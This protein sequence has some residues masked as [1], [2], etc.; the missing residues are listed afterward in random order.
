MM[1]D[2]RTTY[3]LLDNAISQ[4][5]F[6]PLLDYDIATESIK[7]AFVRSYTVSGDGL[8]YTFTVR[9]DVSW[10]H[11]RNGEVSAVR[12]VTAQDA[13][14]SSRATLRGHRLS[15]DPVSGDQRLQWNIFKCLW[16]QG[17][18]RYHV[19]DYDQRT[20]ILYSCAVDRAAERTTTG[21]N[22]PRKSSN[23]ILAREPLDQCWLCAA[24]HQIG[25]TDDFC[26]RT[27][28]TTSIRFAGNKQY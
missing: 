24:V 19:H 20:R 26:V 8:V 17:S 15:L 4:N 22:P 14:S 21:R 25:G 23:R 10:V 5:L 28:S 2:L 3:F 11:F 18:R 1:R 6:L 13:V 9:S 16:N 27:Q 7:P 12:P